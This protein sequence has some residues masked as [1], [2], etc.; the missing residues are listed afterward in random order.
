MKQGRGILAGW[1]F[2]AGLTMLFLVNSCTDPF[3]YYNPPGDSPDPIY[4]QIKKIPEFSKKF[5]ATHYR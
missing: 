3:D 5:N 1:V 2:I 4:T